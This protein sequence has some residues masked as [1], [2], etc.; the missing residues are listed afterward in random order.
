MEAVTSDTKSRTKHNSTSRQI[1]GSSLM[2]VGRTI[3]MVAN[4]AICVLIVRYLSKAN[5]G[6]FAYA[7][8]FVTLGQTIATFG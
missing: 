3:S 6:A 4:S 1:R 8:S 2:L 5:Y 7:M